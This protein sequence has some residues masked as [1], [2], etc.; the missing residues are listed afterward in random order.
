MLCINTRFFIFCLCSTTT[1]AYLPFCSFT[2]LLLFMHF[3]LIEILFFL[4][5]F[6]PAYTHALTH[7]QVH[8]HSAALCSYRRDNKLTGR[9]SPVLQIRS[10]PVPHQFV[11]SSLSCREILISA[12]KFDVSG[13][14][15]HLNWQECSNYLNLGS[16]PCETAHVES[17][18]FHQQHFS[19]AQ[20]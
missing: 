3:S 7:A 16:I 2:S 17:F 6:L 5:L 14:W 8:T 19:F 20:L 13:N 15:G 9:H 4:L 18:S 1:S 10:T 11:T 12:R